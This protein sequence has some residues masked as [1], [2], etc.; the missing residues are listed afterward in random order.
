LRTAVRAALREPLTHFLLFGIAIF[1]AAHAIE[2]HSRRYV[3]DVT[4]DDLARMGNSY[5]QQYGSEPSPAQL[6]TMVDNYIREEIFLRE[7]LAL[8]LDANDE[9][10][11]RRIAQKFDFLQQDMATP[12]QP[13][14]A[15]VA[16]WYQAHKADFVAPAR[17][18]FDQVYFAIDQRGDGA[19]RQLAAAAVRAVAGAALPTGDV[20]PGPAAISQLSRDDTARLFGGDAFANAVFAAPVGRWVGPYRSGFGWHLIRVTDAL[21]A[22]ERSLVE[23]RGDVRAAWIEAD[24]LARNG[25]SYRTLLARY[26]VARADQPQ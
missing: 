11:R 26:R 24:R 25:Q 23:V 12:R 1:I 21:P 2:A 13:S 15:Q 18:S 9:I 17:R 7:G 16:E 22:R 20:L 6:S 19:A 14:E 10:V 5:V 4:R 8:K 3:I